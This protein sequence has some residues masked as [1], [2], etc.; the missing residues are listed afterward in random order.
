MMLAVAVVVER[1]MGLGDRDIAAIYEC[2]YAG[3]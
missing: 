2:I 1:E 3:I